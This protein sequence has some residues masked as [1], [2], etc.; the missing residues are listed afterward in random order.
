[1]SVFFAIRVLA[2]WYAE[3]STVSKEEINQLIPL[4]VVS[5]NN[6]FS[7]ISERM[8][9]FIGPAYEN[10][11]ADVDNAIV[12]VKEG[13]HFAICNYLDALKV[14][15]PEEVVESLVSVLQNILINVKDAS[16]REKLSSIKDSLL[17]AEL[18]KL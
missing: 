17:R 18:L 6:N 8:I 12:F 15:A 14:Y 11:T 13:G 2:T 16:L 10:I 1:M 9:E 5:T 4:F 3:E 7:C